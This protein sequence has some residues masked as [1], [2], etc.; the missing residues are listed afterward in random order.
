MPSAFTRCGVVPSRRVLALAAVASV[1][2]VLSPP[3][4]RRAD[5]DLVWH[6]AQH[7]VLLTLTGPVLVDATP[8]RPRSGGVVTAALLAVA[9]VTVWHAPPL[10]DAAAA[11]LL[12]HVAEH[13]SFIVGSTALWWLA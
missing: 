13:A 4:D 2:M 5:H 8:W 10:F 12:I 7:L 9:T 3:F 11:H 6:M 1:A